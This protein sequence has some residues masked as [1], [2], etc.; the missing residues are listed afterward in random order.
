MEL[1][2]PSPGR[3][4]PR[5]RLDLDRVVKAALARLDAEGAGALSIRNTA[6]ALGDRLRSS[7]GSQED[8]AM[9]DHILEKG[10]LGVV[11]DMGAF[12]EFFA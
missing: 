11:D 10:I 3:R 8:R 5:R 1:P 12:D 6:A 7:R 4:G 9:D 2:N